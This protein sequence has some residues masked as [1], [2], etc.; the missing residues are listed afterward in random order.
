MVVNENEQEQ[1]A[2]AEA[3]LHSDALRAASETVNASSNDNGNFSIRI[4]VGGNHQSSSDTQQG[5]SELRQRRAMPQQAPRNDAPV[6]ARTIDR[7]PGQT[8]HA[9]GPI[10]PHGAPIQHVYIQRNS[11]GQ[12][13]PMRV[14]NRQRVRFVRNGQ[15]QGAGNQEGATNNNATQ[16]NVRRIQIPLHGARAVR[17]T[18]G[19]RN[20]QV[21]IVPHG[22]PGHSQQQQHVPHVQLPPLLPQPLP[23]HGQ[24][25]NTNNETSEQHHEE[26][27]EYKCL[28]CFGTSIKC[29]VNNHRPALYSCLNTILSL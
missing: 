11:N 9:R 25:S 15:Q 7:M 16:A 14:H 21:R 24:H 29:A 20:Q 10:Q 18:P 26:G 27:H 28:I 19:N 13:Q 6:H 22:T 23:Y 3:L 12:G 5:A 2:D 4:S 8:T 1:N 17:V